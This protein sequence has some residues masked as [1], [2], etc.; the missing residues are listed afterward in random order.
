MKAWATL[1]GGCMVV[2]WA[3]S[4]CA[5]GSALQATA[6]CA[7]PPSP[8]RVLCEVNAKASSGRLVWSDVLVVRAPAFARPL[9]SR[10]V[11]VLGTS[12]EAAT[13]KLALVA[14]QVGQGKLE[15]LMRGVICKEANAAEA[16]QTVTQ[17][18]SA[19]LEV[20]PLP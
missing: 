12:Q 5:D 9:R 1:L 6:H 11:A 8:G 19:P 4:V 15:L 18:L 16:C 7:H 2:L 17:A 10:V 20:G 14:G 3:G 13:A